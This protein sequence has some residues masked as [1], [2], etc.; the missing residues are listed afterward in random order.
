MNLLSINLGEAT[1]RA[2]F[3]AFSVTQGR[4]GR[5][6]VTLQYVQQTVVAGEVIAESELLAVD[7]TDET[8]RAQPQFGA[9]Y[10]LIQQFC[11]GQLAEK[12]PEFV[13]P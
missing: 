3:R 10:P 12:C 13:D 11:R 6:S 1:R 9:M 2:A 8:I 7:M 4:D 5:Y